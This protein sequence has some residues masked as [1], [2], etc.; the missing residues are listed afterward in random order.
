M[1]GIGFD[2]GSSSVKAAIV[3]LVSG[4]VLNK[5]QSP[6][7]ELAISSVNPGWAEQDPDIWWDH[8]INA[9][10]QLFKGLDPSI[11]TQV[12]GIGIAY[13]MH[14]LV[15]LDEKGQVLRPSIIWCDS[16]AVETGTKVASEL[17][18]DVC[19]KRLMNLPGNFTGSKVKWVKENEP[20]IYDNIATILLPGDFINYKL[21]GQLNTTTGGLTESMLWDFKNH[22]VADFTLDAYGIKRSMIPDVA[23]T[24]SVQGKLSK[25][26]AK[27]LGLPGGTPV[28][29]RSGDQPNNAMSLGVLDKGEIAATGGTSG[30]IYAVNDHP[31]ADDTSKVNTFSHVNYDKAKPNCGILLCINGA[32]SMYR[33]LR[34]VVM[35]DSG[36]LE[37]ENLAGEIPVGSEGLITIPFGNGS[38]RMLGNKSPGASFHGIDVNLHGNAHI[39][40]STLEGLAFAFVYGANIL[41]EMDL[42]LKRIVAGNDN[43]FQSDIFSSTLST[44]LSANIELK[45]TSGAVGAAKATGYTLGIYAAVRDAMGDGESAGEF[46]PNSALKSSMGKAYKSWV[47]VLENQLKNG[48]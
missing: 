8:L 45:N 31:V 16:R 34:K 44:L 24:F 13:Q 41:K 42:N 22:S 43:L 19:Y 29:Y 12:V 21:T 3:N 37:M 7:T 5:S 4:D 27:L 9:T 10:D 26:S 30:V 33:W 23:D 36:Y 32:G 20:S 46:K 38:E 6:D 25:A 18:H 17:G 14:G 48:R 11:R 47:S 35:P 2:I 39:I 1:F 40:R 28:C 15:I